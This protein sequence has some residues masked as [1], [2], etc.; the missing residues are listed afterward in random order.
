MRHYEYNA[1]FQ[2]I[3]N[4]FPDFTFPESGNEVS[5]WISALSKYTLKECD[6]AVSSLDSRFKAVTPN[7]LIDEIEFARRQTPVVYVKPEKWLEIF[8][9][10]INDG[11]CRHNS[12]VYREAWEL[13]KK[14]VVQEFR[15]ALK[16][17]YRT[18][19]TDRGFPAVDYEFPSRKDFEAEG[20]KTTIPAGEIVEL[21][22]K[23]LDKINNGV[24]FCY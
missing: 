18:R 8:D 13:F 23:I 20:F 19:C 22:K 9:S 3:K 21:S 10:D 4:K 24:D 12:Y 14:K 2:A 1:L 5:K 16:V 6:K 7:I 15:E 11:I 17:A